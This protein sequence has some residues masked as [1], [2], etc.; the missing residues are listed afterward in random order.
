MRT[1]LVILAAGKGTRMNSDLPKVLQPIAQA[2]MLAHAMA[3]GATLQPEKLIIV[4]GHGAEAVSAAARDIDP[5]A[6][7]VLQEEQLGTAHAVDQARAALE[8]FNGEV[9]VLYGDTPFVQPETLQR[10]IAARQNHDVVILGFE[11]ADPARYGRLVM[12][13]E[14]LER[15]VEFKDASDAER[16]ITFCNSGL[17]ACDAKLLFALI[18]EVGNDNASGEYYL[19]DVVALARAKG[20]S[21]TAVACPEEETLGVDSRADLAAADAVF[22][23]RARAELMESGV[24][25][26]APE[27]VYLS[28]DTVI[29]R[30]TVIEPNVVFGPGVTVESGTS[31]RAFSHLEGCHVSRGSVIGPYARLRPGAELAENTRIGNFVEIKNATLDAGAKVNHLSYIGDASVGAET[32]IGAGTIT[33][34]YDGVMKHKTEIGANAFI[35]SNTMLVAPV[36]VGDNAMTAT[37]SVITR[38]VEADAL[39]LARA[40]QENKPGRARKL[41]DLLKAKKKKRDEGAV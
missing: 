7:V 40:P 35:G 32:N 25:L 15:I 20:H 14:T 21:V 3:A 13:G 22:Q 12:Q 29:G 37:G 36:S 33:C 24:T 6:E 5:R 9:V 16:A 26:M 38:S 27:T 18:S 19:P 2:P 30:D 39:A 11:A 8:D 31:L 10:M 28:L 41:F 4:A 1:A 23:T 17:L 34:N